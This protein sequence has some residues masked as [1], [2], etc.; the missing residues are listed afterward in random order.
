MLK[1]SELRNGSLFSMFDCFKLELLEKNRIIM[2]FSNKS[3]YY[4]FQQQEGIIYTE[5]RKAYLEQVYRASSR[6]EIG[7][8]T[9]ACRVGALLNCNHNRLKTA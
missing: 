5:K 7:T 4:S 8:S 1:H 2:F 3:Y 9:Y 6:R